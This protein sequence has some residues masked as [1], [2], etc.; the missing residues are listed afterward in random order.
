MQLSQNKL[1]TPGRLQIVKEGAP[2]EEQDPNI[3]QASP[4][5][6]AKRK[7]AAADGAEPAQKPKKPKNAAGVVCAAAHELCCCSMPYV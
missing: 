3:P 6:P 4:A 7:K 1:L 5:K 2:L